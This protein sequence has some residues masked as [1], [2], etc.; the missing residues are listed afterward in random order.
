MR[1]QHITAENP[2]AWIAAHCGPS[3]SMRPQHITAENDIATAIVTA[4]SDASMRPQHITA[5]NLA[6][7]SAPRAFRSLQ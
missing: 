6:M 4:L 7:S 3:A 2:R 1:P 5:E